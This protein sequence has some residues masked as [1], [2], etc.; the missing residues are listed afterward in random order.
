M[1]SA[2]HLIQLKAMKSV[3]IVLSFMCIMLSISNLQA[4]Q[5]SVADSLASLFRQVREDT[6]TFDTT[7]T[8]EDYLKL[9]A[10][11]CCGLR[12]SFYRW[13]SAKAMIGFAGALENPILSYTYGYDNFSDPL[14]VR[15]HKFGLMQP[16]P[17]F[18]MLGARKRAAAR[19]ADASY[20][21]FENERLVTRFKVKSA[22]FEYYFA[23]RQLTLT[24]ANFELMRQFESVVRTRYQAGL[25]MHPDLIKAQIELADL[26]NM[27][28]SMERMLKP[29]QAKLLAQLNLPDTLSLPI[30]RD[31]VLYES[32]IDRDTLIAHAV[33][34]SPKLLGILHEIESQREEITVARKE[35]RPEFMVGVEYERSKLFDNMTQQDEN[36]NDYMLT[37]QMT[38][39]I[40]FGK[41]KAM[42]QA[43][44]AKAQATEYMHQEERNDLAA[45][46]SMAHYEYED[47][48]RR[49]RLYRDGLIPKAQE[50]LNVNLTAYQAGQ[51]DF[52]MLLDSQRQLLEFE[53]NFERAKTDAA[54]KLAEIEVLTGQEIDIKITKKSYLEENQ[55]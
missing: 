42:R 1:T 53:T 16:I 23:A 51:I 28:V 52:L 10:R 31:F 46:V 20:Q 37:V 39:P 11:D 6:P 5:Q 17:W 33:R 41:N 38:L 25:A 3:L 14:G 22:Y 2:R 35:A 50:G 43:A 55:Q 40:W 18:G 7:T 8:L 19:M 21:G 12:A 47:A 4:R 44:E 30:P 48:L 54:I 15:S 36:M 34:Y 45:M 9:G 26:E 24:R 32:S 49:M 27:I 29:A 13:Q